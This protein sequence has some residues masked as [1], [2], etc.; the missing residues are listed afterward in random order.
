MSTPRPIVRAPADKVRALKELGRTFRHADAI[1]QGM[2]LLRQFPTDPDVL[3]CLAG[4]CLALGERDRALY[5]A[6]E[7]EALMPAE[8]MLIAHTA[9]ILG[10]MGNLDE[11]EARFR[12]VLTM[13]PGDANFTQGLIGVLLGRRLH[14]EIEQLCREGLARNPRDAKLITTLA[15]ALTGLNRYD[16]AVELLEREAPNHP[17]DIFL[18]NQWCFNIHHVP[19]VS[20]R[21][22]REVHEKFNDVLERLAPSQPVRFSQSR[23]PERR[24]R[25]GIVSPDLITNVVATF[26]EPVFTH[27][28]A[29]QFEL[30]AYM[31]RANEDHVTR[32]LREKTDVWRSVPGL[33]QRQL[34][35]KL[36]DDRLDIVID[37]C[38]HAKSFSLA[39]LH[40]RPAPVQFTYL[41]YAGT[42]GVK[43]IDYRIVD[44]ITDPPGESDTHAVERLVRLD[45]CFVCFTP[46]EGAPPVADRASDAPHA[47]LTF[48][49]FNAVRKINQSVVALWSR[50]LRETPGSRLMLKAFDLKDAQTRARMMERFALEGIDRERVTLLEPT[51]DAT[52]HLDAYRHIDI[53]LDP[54]PYN[55]TTTTCEAMWMGVPVVTLIGDRHAA[56][57]GASLLT[58]VG[59]HECIAQNP[60]E[61]IRLCRELATDAPRRTAL[62]ATLRERLRS[63]PLM[64]QPAFSRRFYAALRDAWR[65][66]CTSPAP[67]MP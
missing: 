11:A 58:V 39:A 63:S 27:R 2:R 4:S 18:Y 16:E 65:T 42:T 34:G 28:D 3:T 59:M 31:T 1:E 62:R 13:R 47:P 22:V 52:S 60:D 19:D 49:S 66:W 40:L 6:R 12:R 55:G 36:R 17:T 7:A 46:P 38:G 26:I 50:L 25:I 8:P 10:T 30:Y 67:S 56:R 64:D 35:D 15:Y 33:T 23:D 44:S 21:K 9:H 32:R 24:L 51:D 57:V 20:P 53:G 14:A 41:G 37:L 5:F 54:F 48:G 29:A 61:Y 43:A 45:P